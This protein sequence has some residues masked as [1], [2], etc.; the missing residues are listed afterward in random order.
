VLTSFAAAFHGYLAKGEK[1]RPMT[2]HSACF[3]L[4]VIVLLSSCLVTVPAHAAVELGYFEIE[5]GPTPPQLLVTWG[6]E[7]ERDTIEFLVKR[8]ENVNPAQSTLVHRAPA[9]GSAVN[10]ADYQFTDADVTNGRVY[11]YWLIELTGSGQEREVGATQATAGGGTAL[12]TPTTPLATATPT[13][14][15]ATAA[16]T[17]PP[18][19]ATQGTTNAPQ[20]TATQ[21]PRTSASTPTTGALANTPTSPPSAEGT[22]PPATP[23]TGGNP[24]PGDAA[25]Q[26]TVPSSGDAQQPAQ[27]TDAPATD[28]SAPEAGERSQNQDAA[29][30][31]SATSAP[32]TDP[33]NTTTTDPASG[34][35]TSDA[36]ATPQMLAEAP[37][38]PETQLVRP[39]ATPRP[40][41]SSGGD[42]NTSSLLM[43]IGGGSLCGA[44]LLILVVV[45]VW[46][47]R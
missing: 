24:T 16:P 38:A 29:V 31:D 28:A 7:T 32:A 41:D 13:T 18:A 37:A 33:N 21:T 43:V 47:R 10:G 1:T 30:Q 17:V 19:A 5:Q 14:R 15:P 12:P 27:T 23:T 44:V 8:G 46:R 20:P 25:S 36:T 34:D 26:P 4:V 3:I 9:R 39:T 40:S 35:P 42:D 11:Y 45:F 22:N 6:T 2:R